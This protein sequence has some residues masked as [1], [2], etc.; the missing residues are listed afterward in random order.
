MIVLGANLG[1]SYADPKVSCSKWGDRVGKFITA[2]AFSRILKTLQRISVSP[3]DFRSR[4]DDTSD[5]LLA[6]PLL[7]PVMCPFSDVH[8]WRVSIKHKAQFE[9]NSITAAPPLLP[10]RHNAVIGRLLLFGGLQVL[11]AGGRR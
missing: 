8:H 10:L 5:N 9:P 3:L 11:E 4:S 2:P 1:D 6:A 7:Y